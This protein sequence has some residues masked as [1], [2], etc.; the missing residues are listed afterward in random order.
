MLFFNG[1]V[2]LKRCYSQADLKIINLINNTPTTRTFIVMLLFNQM[3][4]IALT[5][6]VKPNQAT[7]SKYELL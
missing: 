5:I 6:I 1:R 3:M 2:P 4:F 7:T